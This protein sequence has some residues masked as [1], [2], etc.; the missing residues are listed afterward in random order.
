MKRGMRH[1]LV[2]ALQGLD[3]GVKAV[4]DVEWC[5]TDVLYVVQTICSI[6]LCIESHLTAA[7]TTAASLNEQRRAFAVHAA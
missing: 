6:L 7:A 1:W 4:P 3:C 2:K 5:S